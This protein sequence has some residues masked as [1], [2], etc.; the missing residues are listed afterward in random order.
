VRRGIRLGVA[1]LALLTAACGTTLQ[2][3]QRGAQTSITVDG[4]VS[5]GVAGSGTTGGTAAPSA[6]STTAPD[7]SASATSGA[8]GATPA[9]SVT[10]G[11][12]GAGGAATPVVASHAPILVGL[13]YVDQQQAS[14]ITAGIGSGLA[15][16]D[17]KGMFGALVADLNQHGGILGHP[18]KIVYYRIDPTSSQTQYEQGAC[19]TFTQDNHVL[20]ALGA[21]A[22]ANYM[23]CIVQHGAAVLGADWSNLLQSDY[24]NLEWVLQPDAIALDRL[25]RIQADQFVAEGLFK[26]TPP[27]KV[28]VLYFDLPQFAAAEKILEQDL[29][30]HGVG[31]AARQAFNYVGSTGDIGTTEAQ[32]QAAVLKFHSQGVTHVIGVETNAWLI[33]FFG[34][35]AASQGYYPRYGYTSDEVLS[36]VAANVPARALQGALVIG[37]WPA[38]DL[39]NTSLYPLG[40]CETVRYLTAALTAGGEP[41]SRASLLAGARALT[42][43]SPTDT[44]QV[45]ITARNF[46]GVS[47]IRQGAWNASCKCF[48]YTSGLIPVS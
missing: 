41:V 39:A 7:N 48:A 25:A 43:Y 44:L 47:A 27:V 37:W 46:D 38:Q 36:N 3:S 33:G 19:A 11:S 20:V 14:V 32:V 35:D 2:P 15:T 23:R 40:T 42:S 34:L 28:G 8:L 17:L 24:A 4:G 31:V 12:T 6:S 21:S 10:A 29:A 26:S 18:V 5:T 16:G 45:Q 30:Q 9:D 13:P 1:G 22:S